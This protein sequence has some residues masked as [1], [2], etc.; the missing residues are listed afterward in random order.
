MSI[1]GH[2][3]SSNP[4]ISTARLTWKEAGA[5][6]EQYVPL[7]GTT[8]GRS[9]QNSLMITDLAAS[10]FHC[11]VLPNEG[12][13]LL[14]DLDSTNGTFL[15]GER[16]SGSRGL[17]NGDQIKIG[18][19]VFDVEITLPKAAAPAPK[20]EEKIELPLE[21]TFVVPAEVDAPWLVISSG[22]GKGTIFTMNKPR[23]Q[24]GRA[25][26]DK[27]WD[28]DLVDK[29]VS[30]PHAELT[31]EG[32]IWV[33]KD[34]RSANGTTLNGVRVTEPQTLKDGDV[35]AFGETVL[36]FRTKGG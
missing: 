9:S 14:V 12:S 26:R 23:I 16:L 4:T 34:M 25:S 17:H 29:S 10:R 7:D 5:E 6:K 32:G 13:F 28:I 18:D 2:Y 15:N 33:L 35:I 1:K 21:R 22:T 3:M 27:Q 11:K 36:V 31:Q 30:R 8:I 20:E 19:L 24:I